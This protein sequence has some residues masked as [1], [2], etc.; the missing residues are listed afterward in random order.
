MDIRKWVK[1][2]SFKR[3]LLNHYININLSSQKYFFGGPLSNHSNIKC[4]ILNVFTDTL[5]YL[6]VP[7][8]CSFIPPLIQFQLI[9]AYTHLLHYH[10]SGNRLRTIMVLLLFV[11]FCL[12]LFF[13]T[14]YVTLS[15]RVL[16]EMLV[17]LVHTKCRRFVIVT[18]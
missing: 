18:T 14:F 17:F 8:P 15:E 3:H 16:R 11:I 12:F 4:F 2:I 10:H 13:S 1:T 5:L 9:L 6:T 7:I